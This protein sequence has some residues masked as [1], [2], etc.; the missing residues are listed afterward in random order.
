[1]FM[2]TND[3]RPKS[4]MIAER[5]L[6][7]PGKKVNVYVYKRPTDEINDDCRL[8]CSQSYVNYS[9]QVHHILLKKLS[10]PDSFLFCTWFML[11]HF[12]SVNFYAILL[13]SCTKSNAYFHHV[14]NHT[15]DDI[16][17]HEV[18]GGYCVT[19]WWLIRYWHHPTPPHPTPTL[20]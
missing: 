6:W 1:M 3:Q 10:H 20:I 8:E 16:F 4:M 19:H 17:L 14:V 2:Y 9:Q 12:C 5:W 11:Y 18:D 13:K 15:N 7:L